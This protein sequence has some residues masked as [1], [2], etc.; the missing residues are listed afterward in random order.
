MR[1]T[2]FAM[3]VCVGCAVGEE[4]IQPPSEPDPAVVQC[5]L[6]E[7]IEKTGR[8]LK[9]LE[10]SEKLLRDKIREL[11]KRPIE[12]TSTVKTMSAALAA[13]GPNRGRRDPD[14]I[15]RR[16]RAQGAQLARMFVSED[17]SA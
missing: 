5:M 12:Q 2:A 8:E 1:K 14:N 7:D 13:S 4:P 9:K 10:K 17:S 16:T 6:L 3:L 15:W 11:E